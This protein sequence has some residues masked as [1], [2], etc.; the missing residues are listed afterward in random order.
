MCS[1][2][3]PITCLHNCHC[4][5]LD[6]SLHGRDQVLPPMLRGFSSF[7]SQLEKN[8]KPFQGWQWTR[9][10]CGWLQGTCL[11]LFPDLCGHPGTI[12]SLELL[13]TPRSDFT[14]KIWSLLEPFFHENSNGFPGVSFV[15]VP[16]MVSRVQNTQMNKRI[17]TCFHSTWDLSFIL[18]MW[19]YFSY[20][21][22]KSIIF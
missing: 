7:Q 11:P 1:F 12:A 16:I 13:L 22:M 5:S 21:A 17:T 9:E 2:D 8:L 4:L 19:K 20:L 15:Y 18:T 14:L 10:A 6:R 3:Q